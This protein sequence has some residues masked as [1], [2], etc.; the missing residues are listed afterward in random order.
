MRRTLILSLPL[1]LAACGSTVTSLASGE[2]A[3]VPDAP[4]DAPADGAVRSDDAPNGDGA[5]DDARVHDAPE[6]GDASAPSACL[7]A[8]ERAFPNNAF[9]LAGAQVCSQCSAQCHNA[10]PCWENQSL[11]KTLG[12]DACLACV[13]AALPSLTAP[14]C[15]AS[16]DC[17]GFVACIG[18][19]P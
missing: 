9:S 1:A 3:A 10:E 12:D 5:F 14:Y 15:E 19:C 7:A 17:A 8:C 2:D 6:P 13:K 4:S 11:P 18:S 16:P